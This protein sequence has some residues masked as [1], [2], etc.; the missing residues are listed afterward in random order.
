M[1]RSLWSLAAVILAFGALAIVGSTAIGGQPA[2]IGVSGVVL[3]LFGLYLAAAL[4][5]RDRTW[6]RLRPPKPPVAPIDRVAG[7]RI[8]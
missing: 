6:K 8:F 7:R 5:I 4:A 1:R 2:P 3:T